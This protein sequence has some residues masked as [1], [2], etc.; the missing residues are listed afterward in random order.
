MIIDGRW[1]RSKVK[2]EGRDRSKGRRG[3]EDRVRRR[4]TWTKRKEESRW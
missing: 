2:G 4:G 3:R 1:D